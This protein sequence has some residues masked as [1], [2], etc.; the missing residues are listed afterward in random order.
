MNRIL[1]LVALLTVLSS[2]VAGREIV[3][4]IYPHLA[5][6]NDEGECGTG[7]GSKAGWRRGT[8]SVD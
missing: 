6:S 2:T 8:R 5:M 1:A 4:G 3:D 7:A